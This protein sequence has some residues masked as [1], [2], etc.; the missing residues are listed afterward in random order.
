MFSVCCVQ[1]MLSSLYRHRSVRAS[2]IR[3]YIPFQ[4]LHTDSIHVEIIDR[5]EIHH[6]GQSNLCVPRCPGRTGESCIS[7]VVSTWSQNEHEGQHPRRAACS[8]W[9][10]S[11]LHCDTFLRAVDG[12]AMSAHGE[13]KV[14][15]RSRVVLSFIFQGGD[16]NSS[17]VHN[18]EHTPHVANITIPKIVGN[19]NKVKAKFLHGRHRLKKT[20]R[21]N[22]TNLSMSQIKLGHARKQSTQTYLWTYWLCREIQ[23]M[24]LCLD[25]AALLL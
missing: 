15:E 12:C 8:L 21:V 3:R 19:G 10:F 24:S 5:E 23:L 2:A 11:I 4:E 22:S 6:N 14:V 17:G 7:G 1:V 13:L 18:T 20:S 16:T 25:S 9:L